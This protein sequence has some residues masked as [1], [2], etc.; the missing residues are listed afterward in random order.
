MFFGPIVS[1]SSSFADE[2]RGDLPPFELD[3]WPLSLSNSS[4]SMTKLRN[5]CASS[6]LGL[7]DRLVGRVLVFIF[8][9][10]EIKFDVLPVFYS[11]PEFWRMLGLLAMC[12]L[13]LT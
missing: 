5:S 1:Q 13:S 12:G 7:P 9:S 10:A 2:I 8:C 3:K 11:G 6:C 4:C